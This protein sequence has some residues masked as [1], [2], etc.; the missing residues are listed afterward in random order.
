MAE[1]M[2]DMEQVEEIV[3]TDLAENENLID[4]DNS[5]KILNAGIFGPKSMEDINGSQDKP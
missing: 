1:D 2:I 5:T 3:R 4:P